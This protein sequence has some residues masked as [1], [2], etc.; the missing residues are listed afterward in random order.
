MV[1]NI[2]IFFAGFVSGSIMTIMVLAV[3]ANAVMP[4]NEELERMDE[5]SRWY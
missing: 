2:L 5:E 3:I 1:I 4:S